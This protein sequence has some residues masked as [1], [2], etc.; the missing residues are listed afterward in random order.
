MNNRSACIEY[1]DVAVP[2]S[3]SD[4]AHLR[5]QAATI[6]RDILTEL[7]AEGY[8]VTT[9]VR[10]EEAKAGLAKLGSKTILGSLDDSDAIRTAAT[11]TDIMMHTATT[12]HLP[13]AA[14]VL[15][16]IAE[17]AKAGKSTIYIHTSGCSAITDGS[18]DDHVSDGKGNQLSIQVSTMARFAVKHGYAGEAG[19]GNGVW[20][21]I[22]V[23]DLARGCMTI[24]HYM[25]STSGDRVL[26]S[27]YFF[28]KNGEEY[29]W[30]RYAEEVGKALQKAGKI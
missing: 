20:G 23:A 27:P 25:K 29:L 4:E 30:E 21:H 17:R 9:L 6:T 22:H 5:A 24:L 13:S 14:S 16:G 1:R 2:V 3:L 28:I 15:D 7:L 12:D 18:N 8:P 11:A 19:G 10:R 26:E